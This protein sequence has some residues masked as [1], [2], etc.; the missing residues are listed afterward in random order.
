MKRLQADLDDKP[1]DLELSNL[2]A[3]E[4]VKKRIREEFENVLSSIRL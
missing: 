4:S 3:S 1:V 2:K